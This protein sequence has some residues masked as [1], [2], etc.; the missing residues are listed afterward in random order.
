MDRKIIVTQDNSKTLLIPDINETYHSTKGALNEAKHV[1]MTAGIDFVTGKNP[2]RIFELGF[3]TGLNVLVTID[4]IWN[5]PLHINYYS[6]EKYPLDFELVRDLEYPDLFKNSAI[7]EINETIH[8]CPWE[9]EQRIRPN[10]ALT[11]LKGDIKELNTN[12]LAVDLIFYDAFGPKV[13]PD[14]WS[15]EV[16]KK[17]H[18]ILTKNGVLVTYCAQGQF[19]RNLKEAGFRVENLP[20]PP[21]K[22]EMTRAIKP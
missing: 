11:K 4:K 17:M 1:F 3:G 9:S 19:K 13:Q 18:L 21:G 7:N 20:G 16:L 6:L 5:Q 12:D 2:L 15:V 22:R 10:F 8:N 14:L